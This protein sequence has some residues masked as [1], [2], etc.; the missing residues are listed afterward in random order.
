RRARGPPAHLRA[1]A[2]PPLHPRRRHGDLRRADRPSPARRR[3]DPPRGRRRLAR[4]PDAR[5][6]PPR[7]RARPGRPLH[8][9]LLRPVSGLG[10]ARVRVRRP[11]AATGALSDGEPARLAALLTDFGTDDVYVGVMKAVLLG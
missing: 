9:L 5:G 10:P 3:R 2:A 4:L 6:G 7:G 8:G 1:A 11:E